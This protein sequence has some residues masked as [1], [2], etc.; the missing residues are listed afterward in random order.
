VVWR[1]LLVRDALTVRT[2]R[3]QA[4]QR[5]RV[6][7]DPRP[8][9]LGR[10]PLGRFAAGLGFALAVAAVA[11]GHPT[12]LEFFGAAAPTPEV[13]TVAQLD[14]LAGP[15]A[16]LTAVDGP[17]AHAAAAAAGRG[18]LFALLPAGLAGDEL[19]RLLRTVRGGSPPATLF[20]LAADEDFF[21]HTADATDPATG[22]PVRLPADLA[23]RLAAH[24]GA[25]GAAGRRLG[26]RVEPLLVRDA[27]AD[28]DRLL[29]YFSD[30]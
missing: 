22:R 28:L 8:V 5:V 13:R 21:P 9:L 27:D 7:L 29:P 25:V 1:D 6:A 19:H 26:V 3:G 20:P 18:R 12:R 23:D 24:L 15:L 17:L 30:L 10:E 11:A 2:F 14:R 4:E 16:D